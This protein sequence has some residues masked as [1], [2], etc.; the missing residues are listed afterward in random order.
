[1]A[2]WQ[3]IIKIS[4][5]PGNNPPLYPRLKYPLLVEKNLNTNCLVLNYHPKKPPKNHKKCTKNLKKSEKGAKNH[6]KYPHLGSISTVQQYPEYVFS[7]KILLTVH[8][9]FLLITLSSLFCRALTVHLWFLFCSCSLLYLPT[10][11]LLP[12]F[13]LFVLLLPYFSVSVFLS[14]YPVKISVNGYNKISVN[15]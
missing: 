2:L 3:K 1:M 6:T 14:G 8:R 9:F 5:I 13:K 12:F 10:F 7:V 11:C 15:P 4:K